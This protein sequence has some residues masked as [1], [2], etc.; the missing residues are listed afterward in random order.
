MRLLLQA[1]RAL[2]RYV[3]ALVPNVTDA[4]DVVQ[5]TAAALWQAADK[6]DPGKPFVPWACRSAL[7][8]GDP[9]YQIKIL[10]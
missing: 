6:L 10:P 3:M 7:P 5:E 9:P 8:P 1:E 2:L 4:R